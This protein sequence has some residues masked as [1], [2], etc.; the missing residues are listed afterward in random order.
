MTAE[1]VDTALPETALVF[2]SLPPGWRDLDLLVRP[3]AE[4]ALE[5]ALAAGGY[6]RRHRSWARF[7][8]GTAHVVDLIPVRRWDVPVDELFA[9]ALPIEGYVRLVRPAPWAALLIAARRG[10]MDG[11]RRAR[12]DAVLAEDPGAWERARA[13][14][15]AWRAVE[16]L[17]RLEA[18]YRSGA[19]LA[20]RPKRERGHVVAISGLDGSGKSSQAEALRDA[21]I[22]AKVDAVVEW[23]RLSQNEALD[24]IARPVKRLLGRSRTETKPVA[25]SR[26]ERD[27]A[28]LARQRSRVATAVWAQVVAVTHS[29]SQRAAVRPHLKAGR[30]V[31]C[32]RYTLD[33]LVNL[34]FRYGA[35]GLAV[36]LLTPRATRAFYLDIPPEESLR[37]KDDGYTI[38]QLRGQH[39]LYDRMARGVIRLDGTRP[40]D[41][42]ATDIA[43]EVW[44]AI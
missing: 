30:V 25:Y 26:T 14:A 12:I 39:E 11:R 40:F 41:D 29:L 43:A 33:S 5:E 22:A 7:G 6:A 21:L 24:A 28:S 37:R 10:L 20:R 35:G 4:R 8:T 19:V 38:E 1:L 34:R 31:I 23:R 17:D 16:A 9:T 42:L 32:D 44:R 36:R 27:A 3:A 15:P 13:A 2:G 18:A